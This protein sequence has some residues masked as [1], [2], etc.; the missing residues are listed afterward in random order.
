MI[1]SIPKIRRPIL[2]LPSAIPRSQLTRLVLIA[3]E[4]QHQGAEVAFAF[5][6]NNQI[7]QHD[8]FPFFPV[9]DAVVTDFSSNVFGTYT[10]SLSNNASTTD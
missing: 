9:A 3:Q 2:T 1:E 5:Q 10:P 8:N 4:L 7:L 6:E